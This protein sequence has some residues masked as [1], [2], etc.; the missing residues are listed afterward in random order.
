MID[1]KILAVS[2]PL[3]FVTYQALSKLLPKDT[4]VFLINAYA[5]LAGFAVM[6]LLHL[7]TAPQKSLGL[8]TRH[9]TLAISIGILIGLGNYGIIKAYSLGAPQSIFTP[10]FYVIIIIYGVLFGLFFWHERL[11]LIQLIGVALAIVSLVIILYS[12]K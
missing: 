5:S 2:T 1:W 3:L 6:M 11:N 7:V 4:S 8:N 10:L 12:K 9:L